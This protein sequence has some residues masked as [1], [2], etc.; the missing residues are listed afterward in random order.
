MKQTLSNGTSVRLPIVM[1][2]T[3]TITASI[4]DSFGAKTLPTLSAEAFNGHSELRLD[5]ILSTLLYDGAERGS[6][7]LVR[8]QAHNIKAVINGTTYHFKRYLQHRGIILSDM[9]S[10]VK[11]PGYE[12]TIPFDYKI[13]D[14]ECK[15]KGQYL[16]ND[17]DVEYFND[18]TGVFSIEIADG[19]NGPLS[20]VMGEES[21]TRDIIART[22]P[23]HPFYLRWLNKYGGWDYFMFACRQ[24]LT[25]TLTENEYYQP[26]EEDGMRSYRKEGKE[27]VEVSSG[28]VD[29]SILDA[30]TYMPLSP[31]IRLYKKDTHEWVPIQIENGDTE[32][33]SDQPTGELVFSFLTKKF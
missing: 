23:E 5:K 28:Q 11:Y 17:Q 6:G 8:Y 3:S 4:Y 26:Y 24:K 29:K 21:E 16:F 30:L 10:F 12:L 15:L 25:T 18:S 27:V 22:V 9:S 7:V 33:F 20:I 14:V 13:R 19:A 1:T 31:D 32:L 2:G